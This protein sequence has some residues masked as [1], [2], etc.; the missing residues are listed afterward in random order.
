MPW[1]SSRFSKPSVTPWTIFAIRL[2]VSPC[3]AR[4]SPRSVGR[5]TVSVPSSSTTSILRLT[6]WLSSPLG[7]FTVTRPGPTD[8]VT[9]SGTSI[10]CFPIRL[11]RSPNVGDDLAADALGRG[12]VPGHHPGRGRDD[13]GSHPTLDPGDVAAADVV[14]A[15]GPRDAAHAGDHRPAVLGVLELDPDH[16][17]DRGCT[18]GSCTS[19]CAAGARAVMS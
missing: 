15:P 16:R 7:P 8:T 4:S 6:P 2:R 10:G 14:A 11:I 12:L 5:F 1:I 9:P 3:T 19:P 17:G 18:P 13:R